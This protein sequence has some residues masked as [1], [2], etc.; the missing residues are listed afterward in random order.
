[1]AP[2]RFNQGWV[3][4]LQTLIIINTSGGAQDFGKLSEK[5]IPV[6]VILVLSGQEAR[7]QE[8]QGEAAAGGEG[9]H[10]HLRHLRQRLLHSLLIEGAQ[11]QAFWDKGQC[12]QMAKFDLQ[13]CRHI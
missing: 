7:N 12:C 13:N 5:V 2:N 3:Q 4:P 10:V 8:K 9:R 11:A 1:M 6:V